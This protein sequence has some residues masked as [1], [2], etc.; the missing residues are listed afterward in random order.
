VAFA[1]TSELRLKL[2]EKSTSK[3]WDLLLVRHDSD[4]VAFRSPIKS[5]QRIAAY[6]GV[7]F[8]VAALSFS[9]WIVGKWK[10]YQNNQ[11][12]VNNKLLSQSLLSQNKKYLRQLKN[13]EA[14]QDLQR[15]LA[16]HSTLP[17]LDLR[18]LASP[19]VQI[20]KLKVDYKAKEK[21]WNLSFRLQRPYPRRGTENFY[22]AILV[23]SDSVIKSFPRILR[24]KADEII[25]PERAFYVSELSHKRDIRYQ[26]KTD[27]LGQEKLQSAY[28]SVLLFGDKGE[29]LAKKVEELH[30][31]GEVNEE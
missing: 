11:E 3:F 31:P 19:R 25:M 17:A 4:W 20:E 23:N 24:S 2:A 5:L 16:S 15:Y 26:F 28:A 6:F 1:I 12:L 9:G 13:K 21:E 10:L 27:F 29:L 18:E 14:S 22:W 30:Y 7:L 8:L